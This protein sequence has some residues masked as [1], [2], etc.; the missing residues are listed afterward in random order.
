MPNEFTHTF[1]RL[2]AESGKSLTQVAWLGGIDRAYLLRLSRGEKVNPSLGTI[3][4]IYIGL[5]FSEELAATHPT[6]TE[7]LSE[8]ALAAA[9]VAAEHQV[10][11]S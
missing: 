4:R 7:G 11:E 9:T 2:L 5:I 8:L 6:F 10:S 1:N 3:T